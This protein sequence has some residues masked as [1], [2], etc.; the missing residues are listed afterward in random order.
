M[1]L[2]NLAAPLIAGGWL[3]YEAVRRLGDALLRAERD[4]ER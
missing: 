2:L 3:L 1:D 4:D